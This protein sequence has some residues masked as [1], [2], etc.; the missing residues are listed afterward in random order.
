MFVRR[1]VVVVRSDLV[2]VRQDLVIGL[3]RLIGSDSV[4]CLDLM[5]I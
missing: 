3:D 1:D 4:T 2:F 5:D